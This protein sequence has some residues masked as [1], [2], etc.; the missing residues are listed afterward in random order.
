MLFARIPVASAYFVPTLPVYIAV[1]FLAGAAAPIKFSKLWPDLAAR[2]SGR[3]VPGSL[4]L[5]VL[6]GIVHLGSVVDEVGA[7]QRPQVTPAA[8]SRAGREVPIK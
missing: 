2:Y 1:A 5:L 6:L 8:S 3:A 7:L 4:I